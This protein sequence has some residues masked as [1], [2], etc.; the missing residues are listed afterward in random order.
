MMPAMRL[1]LFPMVKVDARI[2]KSGSATP[3]SGDLFGRVEN[4]SIANSEIIEIS[5]DQTV[6]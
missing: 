1:S 5:I 3:Q 4:I 6:E 2:S